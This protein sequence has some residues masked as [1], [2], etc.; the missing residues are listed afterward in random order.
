MK[1]IRA[2]GK[3]D[4]YKKLFEMFCKNIKYVLISNKKTEEIS[5]RA[6]NRAEFL[7]RQNTIKQIDPKLQK[8]LELAHNKALFVHFRY[9]LDYLNK[10][11]CS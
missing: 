10:E 3:F 6:V 11:Y 7:R 5:M 1:V 2:S 8:K 4:P 9:L